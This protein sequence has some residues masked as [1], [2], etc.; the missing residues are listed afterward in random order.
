MASNAKSQNTLVKDAIIL[1]AITLISGILLGL[2]YG[3]TKGPIEKA[4]EKATQEAY[5]LVYPDA[6]KF[7]EDSAASD[8]VKDVDPIS[9]KTESKVQQYL[10]YLQLKIPAES[11]LDM[12]FLLQQQRVMAEILIYLWV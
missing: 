10:K 3:V 8:K 9:M 6:D 1:F 7:E 11:R 5:K 2:S 4:N 12:L